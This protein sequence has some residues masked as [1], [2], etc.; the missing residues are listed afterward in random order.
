MALDHTQ[1]GTAV[2]GRPL[3]CHGVV[4]FFCQAPLCMGIAHDDGASSITGGV[5]HKNVYW[6]YDGGNGNSSRKPSY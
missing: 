1:A 6:A 4:L 5:Q 2:H 3:A